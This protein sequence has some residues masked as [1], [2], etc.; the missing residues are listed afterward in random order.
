[1]SR[2]NGSSTGGPDHDVFRFECSRRDCSTIFAGGELASIAKRAARHLNREHGDSFHTYDQFDTIER[3]GHNVHGN[4]WTVTRIPQYVTAFDVMERIGEVDGLLVPAEDGETCSQCY[5]VIHDDAARVDLD[6]TERVDP[7]TTA[8]WW[9]EWCVAER[10]IEAQ[11][12]ANAS[13]NDFGFT[14]ETD[15]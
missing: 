5:H 1:M 4:E 13:L 15:D 2:S 7:D 14:G 12:A 9:C 6:E 10:E 11:A 3:G 8:E